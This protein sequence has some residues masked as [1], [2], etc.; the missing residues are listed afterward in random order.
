MSQFGAATVAALL[1]T[2]YLVAG[3]PLV[4][5]V[6]HRRFEVSLGRDRHARLW[7]YRRL[8]V[9]EWGLVA[10]VLLVV[11][12]APDVDLAALGLRRP[13]DVL[14]WAPLVVVAGVLAFAVGSLL[15]LRSPPA[16]EP[17]PLESAPVAVSALIPRTRVQRRWFGLVS[18]TAGICE[19]VLYRGFFLLVLAAL[20]PSFGDPL[21]V[22]VG[23]LAFGLAHFYQGLTG[24]I[25]TSVLGGVFSYLFLATGSLLLPV[26]L[27]ALIDLR[28]LAI[29][30]GLLPAEHAHG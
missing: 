24:V 23:G 8:L 30:A 5:R 4:G 15:A 26:V 6:L 19:E 7:L 25:S 3:E 20:V 13:S 16:D 2:A 14:T 27:H 11:L 22:V 21:L 1:L 29:P 12:V 9:L 17:S 18:I 28:L 10:L